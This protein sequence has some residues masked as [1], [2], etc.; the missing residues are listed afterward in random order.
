MSHREGPIRV[1]DGS[2]AAQP[3]ASCNL[4]AQGGKRL[5]TCVWGALCFKPRGLKQVP[6]GPAHAPRHVLLKVSAEDSGEPRQRHVRHL[7]MGQSQ[8]C[9]GTTSR[10]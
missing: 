4:S 2:A 8:A 3:R 1:L 5:L 7:P 10:W 6:L 9:V